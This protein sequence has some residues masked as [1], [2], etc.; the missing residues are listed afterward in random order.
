MA[1]QSG[2]DPFRPRSALPDSQ[3]PS[4]ISKAAAPFSAAEY[5]RPPSIKACV[6][7]AYDHG[8]YVREAYDREACVHEAYDPGA[9][10]HDGLRTA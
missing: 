9:Y 4:P 1:S 2:A 5:Q 3:S 6:R 7:E 8:A 10:D